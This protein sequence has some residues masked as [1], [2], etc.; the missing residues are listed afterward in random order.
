[1]SNEIYQRKSVYALS[2]DEKTVLRD[3]F[4]TMYETPAIS[5]QGLVKNV[6]QRYQQLSAILNQYGHYEW[7]DLLFLPWARAYMWWFEQALR[8]VAPGISLPYWDYTSDEAIAGGLP[9]LFTREEYLSAD[10]SIKA[11]PLLMAD[12]KYPFHSYRE[13]KADTS[14][15]QQAAALLPGVNAQTGF[16]DFSL[17]VYPV[18]ILSHSYLGGSSANTQSTSY[19]PVFWFTHCQLDHLW[20]QWQESHNN[21]EAPVSVQKTELLPFTEVTDGKPTMLTGADVLNTIQ[22]GYTYES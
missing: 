11:N 3:A 9:D 12:Y 1:M 19:D 15:L 2:E 8:S 20:W 18:D 17:A 22:L 10:G 5:D 4:H 13:L 7:N 14:L 6:P 21:H 16:V